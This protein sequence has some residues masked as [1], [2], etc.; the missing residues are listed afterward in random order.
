MTNA[1]RLA[2][3]A[4]R[5]GIAERYDDYAHELR[6]AS[7]ATIE[8]LLGAMGA[9]G[10]SPAPGN[11]SFVAPGR[12][13][14]LSGFEEILF[15]DGG[16]EPA[17]VVPA[18]RLPFGYHR[19]RRRDGTLADLIVSPGACFLPADLSVWGWAAQLYSTRSRASW[20]IGDLRDL[21]DLA[22]WAKS[23]SAGALLL[24]PLH[25]PE[26]GVPQQAS[27]YYPSSRRYRNPLYLRIEEVPGAAEAGVDIERIARLGRALDVDPFVDRDAIYRLKLSALEVLWERW[28]GARAFDRFRAD[29][30]S[31]LESYATYVSIAEEHEGNWRRWPAELAYP[32]SPD[33]AR[34]REE[35]AHHVLFHQWIQWLLDRQLS[36]AATEIDLVHDLAVG[37]DPGGADAWQ[38]QD[39]FATGVEVGAPPDQFNLAGQGW[40]LPPFDPWKLRAA[41]YEPFIQTVRASFAHGAGLRIDHVMGL[42]R[43]FWIPEA[44]P[45]TDGTYVSY[46]SEDLLDIVAL[47][48]HRA[49][50]YVIGEDLGTVEDRVRK[51]M[52]ARNMLSYRLMWFE[53]QPPPKFPRRALAA[54]TNHDLPTIA[55]LWTGTDLVEQRAL[56]LEPNERS[57]AA[58]RARLRDELGIDDDAPV[59]EVIEKAYRSLASAPS[60]I[61]LAT[62][63]DACA[64]Q[65]RPNLPGT[66]DERPNWSTAL[67]VAIED[68]DREPLPS[69]IANALS[70]R[71]PAR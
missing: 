29:E 5:W 60:A 41:G 37:V 24:N 61:V 35:H 10:D 13:P 6:R 44:S 50:S 8:A 51:E 42:F 12:D 26:P 71:I 25:A 32:A 64:V 52:S 47:E 31:L 58:I 62:L 66:G 9:E 63:E 69:A 49:G 38:W 65:R 18:N 16:S 43:L 34:W 19:A 4:A 7:L 54:V 48:S 21:R 56:G 33:V 59:A 20:G 45:P 55:G 15:E 22:R 11:T 46:P 67:P 27:P 40:G 30:G 68:L 36:E 14:D 39:L 28:K 2:R 70:G 23:G 57:V 1:Q 53:K 3:R 17:A